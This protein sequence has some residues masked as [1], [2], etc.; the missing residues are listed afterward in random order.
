MPNPLDVMQAMNVATGDL[1]WEY[2]RK[3]P[4]DLNKH[5][6]FPSINRNI[7]IYGD[8]IIDTSADDFVVAVDATFRTFPHPGEMCK[9]R[10]RLR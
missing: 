8:T 2:R 1:L 9:E 10:R 4:D 6:P 7:G 3:P 5:I